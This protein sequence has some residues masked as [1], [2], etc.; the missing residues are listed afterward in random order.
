MDRREVDIDGRR[1]KGRLMAKGR[2]KGEREIG[3]RK[4]GQKEKG[5]LVDGR[6]V[7]SRRGVGGRRDV[8]ILKL[9]AE[10]KLMAV[11]LKGKLI[12]VRLMAEGS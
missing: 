3:R 2:L 6:E 10:G 4:G 8:D 12:G 5:R 9:M 7:D 11:R 1:E